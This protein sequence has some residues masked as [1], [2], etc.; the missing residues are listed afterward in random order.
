MSL[1]I[2]NSARQ[3]RPLSYDVG[4]GEGQEEEEGERERERE[5]PL[6]FAS[7]TASTLFQI[8]SIQYT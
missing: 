6:L 5:S 4:R 7:S 2:Y 8:I 3:E 1:L